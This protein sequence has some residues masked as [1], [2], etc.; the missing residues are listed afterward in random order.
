MLLRQQ[1]C[2]HLDPGK[3]RLLY[4]L[5]RRRGPDLRWFRPH[6]PI[7]QHRLHLPIQPPIRKLLHL[8][9]LLR[10]SHNRPSP[11]RRL[12]LRRRCHDGRVVHCV[13]QGE[14][15]WEQLRGC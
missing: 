3:H 1:H 2:A 13:L 8:R 11:R 12:V 5:H 4:V 14:R 10:R 15:P 6:Q 9:R 7:Q